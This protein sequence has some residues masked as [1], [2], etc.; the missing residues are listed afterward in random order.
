MKRNKSIRVRTR[1]ITSI[2]IAILFLTTVFASI[3]TTADDTQSELNYAFKFNQP[4]LKESQ[5]RSDHFTSLHITGCM[6]VGQD[7][8]GPNIPVKFVKLLIPPGSEVVNVDV[9]GEAVSLDIRDFNLK[10][11]PIVP[12]QKPMHFEEELHEEESY[13]LDESIY[14][15]D[16]SYPSE[17]YK[18]QGISFCR[19]YMILSLA[20][21]PF[22]Y[23][24]SDGEL[25]FYEN[26]DIIIELRES[27]SVNQYYRGNENDKN[28][29]K[30]LVYNS[31]IAD[32]YEDF[33]SNKDSFYYP[34]GLCDPSDNYEYV[35]ITTEQNDLDY[36]D[37]DSS[38]PY[39][40]QSLM[41]KHESYDGLS[42]TL[43]TM[44]EIDAESDYWDSDPLFNDTPAHIREFCR[45]AYED[46]GT[47]YV[48]IG[49][50]DNWIPRRE[51]D[52]AYESNCETDLYWSNLDNTFNDDG[53][54]NWGEEGDGGF[55]LY[56][57]IFIGSLPCDIPQD[58]SNWITKS[59]YY[60]DSTDKDYLENAAFYGGD[61]GWSCQG[62]DFIDYSAI[63]GTDDF[64]GPIPHSDGPYPSWLGFQFGFET[65]NI[66]NV[67]Q[68]FNLSVKWTAES[69]NPGWQG[70]S[71]TNA[72]NGLMNAINNDEVSLL[73]GIAHANAD[74]S[75]DVGKSSWESNYHNT[76]P[77]FIT[78]YG[79]HS[80]DMDASDDGV[81]HAM[82]FHDD[83]ELAF[84]CVYNTGYGWGNLD[85]T[86]SSS[87][88]QQKSFWDYMFDKAN[89]SGSTM[90]W[91]LG[92]AQAWSKDLMAPTIDWTS[93]G[94]PGSWRGIIE[95]CLLFGDPAQRIKSPEKPEHNIGIQSLDVSSHEPANTDIWIYS[96]LF[97]NGKNNETD[98]EVRFLVNGMQDYITTIPFFE[99]DTQEEVAWL[100]HT[101]PS[102][103][104]TLCV[105]VPIIPDENITTDNLLCKDVYFGPDI[106]VIDIQA[107]DVAGL[108]DPNIVQGIIK[109]IG[110][111]NENNINI[112]LIANDVHVETKTISLN[113]DESEWVNFSWDA[114]TSGCGTYDVKVYSVPVPGETNLLNQYKTH[115]VTVV[116]LL[117]AD[118]FETDKGWT[119]ENDAGLNSGEWERG[120][121]IGGGDRGDPISDYDGS[122]QCYVTENIEGDY[123]IDDGITWLMSPALDMNGEEDVT[124]HYA[125]WYSN[126]FGADPN[127]DLFKTYVSNNNGAN[128]TL[129]ETIGPQSTSGW[130]IHEFFI[131]D[132]V[133]LTTEVKIRF[134]A[135][136]L[137]SGSVVEAGI[138][139]FVVYCPCSLE[140]PILKYSPNS[141]DFGAMDVN[142]TDS[143]SFEIWNVGSSILNYTLNESESWVE[144]LPLMGN[145]SGEHDSLSIHVNTTGLTPGSYQCDIDIITNGGNGVFVVN[146]FITSGEEVI[147]INQEDF[148]RGFPIRH[149]IDG[150]WGAAQSFIPTLDSITR[151][152]TQL[153]KFGTPEF[154][155][156]IELRKDHPQGTL[157]DVVTF[158]P[159][160]VPSSWEWFD[161]DFTDVTVSPGINYFI[162]CPPAPSG[163]T[164]S[165]GYEWGYAIENTYPDGSFWF[166]RDGGGL[167]RDLPDSYEFA[168]RTYGYS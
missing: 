142:E 145:S 151:T 108:G 42:C 47:E 21:T 41:D 24:P 100:Y 98:V 131:D 90:N 79:C 84:G 35:I 123:D 34:G 93:S 134:E 102:G 39:N 32:L 70:G 132:F 78:D 106:A 54:N 97:N 29:V 43:V 7:I 6:N 49:G 160:E 8:G 33:N 37:T 168:F 112:Q 51:M 89:N 140:I 59:F 115:E 44:E 95:S 141:H 14:N 155:L 83:A 127:N 67:G 146:L 22:Q 66:L 80:G 61:T 92:K 17:I 4:T 121:P 164:T 161:I 19:G 77:F 82:L 12:Y 11:T 94:A 86:N 1:E 113:S 153:R 38:T 138:D 143:T 62:D 150:D 40:W 96:T 148:D 23:I 144:I 81:L 110:V 53:D 167:W 76:K 30:N 10:D 163:V 2:L 25:F 31:D 125:L 58:V 154:D 119:V 149:A 135:S 5:L 88:V 20:L 107:A 74:M 99:K 18:N 116:T 60:A 109:N 69:P 73:S 152:E 128:W 91:Q 129:V 101:P 165:F 50:D 159:G 118:N 124:V 28:W 45:D 156:T 162:V 55:D 114:L 65:W 126:D 104:R 122:G 158:T 120:I 103:T 57:E 139:D 117:F 52:Y 130:N 166:T 64:L 48:L 9:T 56:S 26:L 68:E 46:W 75:L 157:L 72:V 36:W 85:S 13:D 147:D 136:D 27:E 16:N 111:T 133:D 3:F 137:N 105:N 63:Q 71:E 15:S 87:A